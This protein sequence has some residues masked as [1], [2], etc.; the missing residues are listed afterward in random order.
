VLCSTDSLELFS[1]KSTILFADLWST[2]F[3]SMSAA[4]VT[5]ARLGSLRSYSD[6]DVNCNY[7]QDAS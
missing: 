3:P 5:N 6:D 2:M 4:C 1:N 7:M